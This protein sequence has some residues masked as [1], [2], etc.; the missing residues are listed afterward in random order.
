MPRLKTLK[1]DESFFIQRRD[2]MQ[3]FRIV[4]MVFVVISFCVYNNLAARNELVKVQ[5][6]NQSGKH[7]ELALGAHTVTLDPDETHGLFLLPEETEYTVH[8]DTG[9]R[10]GD[11]TLVVTPDTKAIALQEDVG[12]EDYIITAITY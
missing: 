6:Q 8:D 9:R 5:V 4:P 11:G 7:V 12:L 10:V 3:I 2:G 1:S